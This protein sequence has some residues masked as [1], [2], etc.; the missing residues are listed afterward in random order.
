VRAGVAEDEALAQLRELVAA[1]GGELAAALVDQPAVQAFGP[2][3]ATAERCRDRAGDY[4]LLT[5]SILE[6][7]LVHYRRPRLLE[8]PD[9]DLRLLA[10][11]Y[12]Y[13]LG[14]SRLAA[15][16]DLEA[17]RELADVIA[18]CAQAHAGPEPR[19]D[20]AP[21]AVWAL[22]AIG[23]AGGSWA[24]GETAKQQLREE[25]SGASATGLE[26]ALARA[27]ELGIEQDAQRALIA[28]RGIS[29]GGGPAGSAST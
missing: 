20:D 23:V 10:G 24:A 18:L 1:E 6:G 4:A 15:L 21:E 13:A 7:Y 9:D 28:F 25:L 12:L 3:V 17:V 29:G 27:A 19:Q 14:L 2:L 5:E 11:D 8:P 26:T 22:G 16:G